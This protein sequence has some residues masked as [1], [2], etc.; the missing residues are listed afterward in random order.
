MWPLPSSQHYRDPL[1]GFCICM[2]LRYHLPRFLGETRYHICSWRH[3][4]LVRGFISTF[5]SFVK[6]T[7]CNGYSYV[8][9]IYSPSKR[10]LR[11]YLQPVVCRWFTSSSDAK[12][13]LGPVR[14]WWRGNWGWVH[15]TSRSNIVDCRPYDSWAPRFRLQL[16]IKPM[17]VSAFWFIVRRRWA[18]DW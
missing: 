4:V 16:E 7:F 6:L 9:N 17:I 13:K 1:L 18:A 8:R 12:L 5:L 10:I 15:G 11:K 2:S 3:W 14:I